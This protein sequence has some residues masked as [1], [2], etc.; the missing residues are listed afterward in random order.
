MVGISAE[1]HCSG[2]VPLSPPPPLSPQGVDINA[3]GEWKTLQA[4]LEYINLHV[5]GGYILPW[6]EPAMNTQL[7]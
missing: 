2:C 5:R 6:Q 1:M 3:R 7:R 4:P